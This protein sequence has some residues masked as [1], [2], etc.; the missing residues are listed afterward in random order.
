MVRGALEKL[1]IKEFQPEFVPLAKAL[2]KDCGLPSWADSFN[3]E[4]SFAAFCE[5]ELAGFIF[6]SVVLDE[7]TVNTIACKEQFRHHGVGSMLFESFKEKAVLLGAATVLLE[8]RQSN[9][10]AR[11][12]YKKHGFDDAGLRKNYYKNP[13]ENAVLM[14]LYLR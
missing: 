1:V 3:E 9:V 13:N 2:E 6:G 14:T 12:F 8:V 11:S 7:A 4:L 5:N 10:P